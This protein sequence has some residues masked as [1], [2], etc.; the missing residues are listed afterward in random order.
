[1]LIADQIIA[2]AQRQGVPPALALEVATDE[3]S[4]NPAAIGKAR[5]IGLFQLMPATAAQLGVDPTDVS[6]NIQGG[7]SLLRQLLAQYGDPAKALAAYNWGPGDAQHHR[8][9]YALS[10]YGAG[11]FAHI[12]SSTQ[13]YINK[14]LGNM[15]TQYS[16]TFNPAGLA[17]P[18]GGTS[19][20][21]IPIYQAGLPAIAPSG[22]GSVW[23][24]LAVAVAV[25]LGLGYVLS[26]S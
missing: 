9:D 22:G 1:M 11:W 24:T 19:V 17:A 15:Q 2:E 12:P 7:V 4:L 16:V 26:E 20:L 5:E 13:G 21:N 8:L 25:I 10:V 23:G 14:I 3:S 18:G 6:Q